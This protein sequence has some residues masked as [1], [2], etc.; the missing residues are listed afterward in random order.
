MDVTPTH[1]DLLSH[2][3]DAAT[4]R[5]RVTSHNIANVN[6]PGYRRLEVHFEDALAEQLRGGGAFDPE[7]VRPEIVEDRSGTYRRDGNNVDI[8]QEM[9]RLNK[10]TLLHN[11]W[12]QILSSQLATMRRSITGSQA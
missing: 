10:N 2:M 7:G 8:N 3:L 4:L 5:H 9:A 11:T 6:T 12:V 1:F